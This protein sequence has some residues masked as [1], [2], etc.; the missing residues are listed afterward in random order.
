MVGCISKI[1]STKLSDHMARVGATGPSFPSSGLIPGIPPLAAG[2]GSTASLASGLPAP[3]ASSSVVLPLTPIP[4]DNPAVFGIA[5]LQPVATFSPAGNINQGNTAFCGVNVWPLL[6]AGE[7]RDSS[8]H[9]VLSGEH[10]TLA[11]EV[12]SQM[13]WPHMLLDLAMAPTCPDFKSLSPEQFMAGYTA[14]I[15]MYLPTELDN[16]PVTNMLCHLNCTMTYTLVSD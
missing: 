1:H 12:K 7:V 8:K 11:K 2:A 4:H 3:V 13:Y 16:M 15:L 5:A 14:M 10:S 6:T 9:W